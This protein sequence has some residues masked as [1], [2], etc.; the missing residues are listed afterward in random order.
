M[1]W[2][3]IPGWSG[4]IIPWQSEVMAKAIPQGGTYLEVGVFLGRSL[5]HLGTLRPDIELIAVD[6]WLDEPSGEFDVGFPQPVHRGW[7][8]LGCFEEDVKRHGCLWFAFLALMKEHAPDVL[9]RTRIVRGTAATV[10]LKGPVDAL[11]VD[12]AHDRPNVDADLDTFAPLVK[13]GGIISGHDFDGF[14]PGVVG[15][16]EAR[17]KGR[18]QTRETCW[19]VTA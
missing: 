13:P 2:E 10:T 6:P 7:A 16:V 3:S 9:K 4:D 11:F 14:W 1:S 17:Y 5:A 15:A 12:G 19:W 18:I 8:G